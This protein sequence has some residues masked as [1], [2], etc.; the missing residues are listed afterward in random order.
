MFGGH[1]TSLVT[2]LPVVAKL[3]S[4]IAN[5]APWLGRGKGAGLVNIYILSVLILI[6][7]YFKNSYSYFPIFYLGSG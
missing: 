4:A 7:L 2:F 6:Y 1:H 3:R 5:Q